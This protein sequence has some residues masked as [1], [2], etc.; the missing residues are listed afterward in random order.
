MPGAPE[1][2]WCFHQLSKTH[3]D[4]PSEHGVRASFQGS[5]N[6]RVARVCS[7]QHRLER[8]D[9]STAMLHCQLCPRTSGR[10]ATQSISKTSWYPRVPHPTSQEI[11]F[12]W[13]L[14]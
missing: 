12:F 6:I 3:C 7:R 1:G 13:V 9:L 5:E 2:P 10:K 14:G 8:S 4:R 11:A